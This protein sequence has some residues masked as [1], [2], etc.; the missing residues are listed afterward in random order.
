MGKSR[1][2]SYPE[3][4]YDLRTLEIPHEHKLV[5][6]RN[7]GVYCLTCD[8]EE[9]LAKTKIITCESKVPPEDGNPYKWRRCGE[10]AKLSL[11]GHAYCRQHWKVRSL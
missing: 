9:N 7:G 5:R 6:D 3:D 8:W 1:K 11:D 10:P 4:L 2:M